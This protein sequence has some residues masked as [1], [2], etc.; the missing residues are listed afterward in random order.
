MFTEIQAWIVDFWVLLATALAVVVNLVILASQDKHF[1]GA[2]RSPDSTYFWLCSILFV[3]HLV[4]RY[5]W[6]IDGPYARVIWYSAF[7]VIDIGVIALIVV[8]V[9]LLRVHSWE[10]SAIIIVAACDA[11][12]QLARMVARFY[13]WMPM[14]AS[15][16]SA[17]M[18]TANLAVIMVCYAYPAKVFRMVWK[19]RS[20]Y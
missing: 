3:D 11:L 1:V 5:A 9:K 6:P 8:K 7:A 19:V 2:L 18:T 20:L 16:Y 15:S 10:D 17:L 4:A 14:S 12:V 13:D